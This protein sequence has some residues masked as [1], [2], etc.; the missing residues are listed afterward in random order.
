MRYIIINEADYCVK[1][2]DDIIYIIILVQW[3]NAVN[4]K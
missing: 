2:K 3:D 1:S 4:E